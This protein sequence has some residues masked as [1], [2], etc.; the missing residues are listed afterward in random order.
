MAAVCLLPV[1]ISDV[2]GD[3]LGF[4]NPSLTL[5]S[6][7]DDDV[8]EAV[9]SCHDMVTSEMTLQGDDIVDVMLVSD[10]DEL[11]IKTEPVDLY[12][13]DH[14]Q[15]GLATAQITAAQSGTLTLATCYS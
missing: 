12:E 3:L 2:D 6:A 14:Q 8:E 1:C 11:R 5:F 10:D 4:I 15:L 7:D 13:T 9:T